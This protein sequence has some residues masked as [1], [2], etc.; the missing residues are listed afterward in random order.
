MKTSNV[1]SAMPGPDATGSN[2]GNIQFSPS[3]DS[4]KPLSQAELDQKISNA[5]KGESGDDINSE[6]YHKKQKDAT[7]PN[8]SVDGKFDDGTTSPGA[9][10]FK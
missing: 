3:A 5:A 2:P 10:V 8:W 9:G 1:N 6:K 7:G 4:K